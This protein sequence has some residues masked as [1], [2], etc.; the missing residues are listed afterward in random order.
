MTRVA[1]GLAAYLDHGFAAA[2]ES[3]RHRAAIK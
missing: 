2:A 3:I 1:V